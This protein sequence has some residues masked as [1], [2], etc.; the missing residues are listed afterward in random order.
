MNPCI[1]HEP[2]AHHVRNQGLGVELVG[3]HYDHIALLGE[4]GGHRRI[5]PGVQVLRY[6]GEYGCEYRRAI[7][8]KGPARPPLALLFSF[9]NCRQHMPPFPL[10]TPPCIN[11]SHTSTT[12]KP[13]P[14]PPFLARR[15]DAAVEKDNYGAPRTAAL[16]TA[17]RVHWAVH[18]KQRTGSG[19]AGAVLD[20]PTQGDT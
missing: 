2:F 16:C 9:Q 20:V 11:P 8:S 5:V 14:H 15:P 4:A 7:V 18:V 10:P 3:G 17:L 1:E 19:D 12:Q 6:C 13:P